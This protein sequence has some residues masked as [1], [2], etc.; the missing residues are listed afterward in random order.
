VFCSFSMTLGGE[1]PNRFAAK[2]FHNL[3]P[4]EPPGTRRLPFLDRL[5]KGGAITTALKHTSPTD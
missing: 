4:P 2:I 1:C 5:D 3:R